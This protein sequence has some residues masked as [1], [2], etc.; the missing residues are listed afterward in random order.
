MDTSTLKEA[1]IELM[2]PLTDR[3]A[4]ILS[5][6]E[7]IEKHYTQK[8]R[9]Y[10]NFTHIHAML[11]EADK[12][13]AQLEDGLVV[14]LSI[15]L[16]DIVY[17]PLRKDNERQSALLAQELLQQTSLSLERIQHCYQQILLTTHHQPLPSSTQDDKFLI[18]FD[19]EVLS[20]D[21]ASYQLYCQQIRKEYWMYPAPIYR[22][23]RK[24]AM[25][26]F[27]ERSSIYQ[28]LPYQAKEEMA[29]ANIRREV[30]ELL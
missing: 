20:R 23:G 21:W 10:H 30:E 2:T 27:L 9:A 3:E 17:K 6:W 29:R 12:Y 4:W 28:T 19:L 13:A 25:L 7:K 16:H 1:W 14:Q 11:Q 18:D 15:W 8:N 22:K 26:G 24:Q 5:T